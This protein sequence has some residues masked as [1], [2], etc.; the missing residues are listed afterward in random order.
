MKGDGKWRTIMTKNKRDNYFRELAG[1][2]VVSMYVQEFF[3]WGWQQI[4]QENDDVHEISL[5]CP[6]FSVNY[7]FIQEKVVI[8]RAD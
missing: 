1:L 7:L 6:Y 2:R 8:L 5:I 4:D 3:R